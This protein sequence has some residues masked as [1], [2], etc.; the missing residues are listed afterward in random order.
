MY[1]P[2]EYS[3]CEGL[4]V[5]S[6]SPDAQA[7]MDGT[8]ANS[9]TKDA[10]KPQANGDATQDNRGHIRLMAGEVPAATGKATKDTKGAAPVK[11]PVK[12]PAKAPARAIG[13][14]GPVVTGKP[15]AKSEHLVDG[16]NGAKD[17]AGP[18]GNAE[19]DEKDKKSRG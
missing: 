9:S 12:G 17:K 14:G 5:V 19:P 4:P 16:K 11:P 2:L 10:A 3:G 18:T 7:V 6:P 13:K 1:P 8:I 15:T